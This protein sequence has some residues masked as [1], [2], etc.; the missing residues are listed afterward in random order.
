MSTNYTK[1]KQYFSYAFLLSFLVLGMTSLTLVYGFDLDYFNYSEV[2]VSAI[3]NTTVIVSIVSLVTSIVTLLGY[4]LTAF[5]SW[6]KDKR[7]QLI[8]DIDL[9]KKKLEVE[10]LRKDINK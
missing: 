2:E 9:E 7:E 5:L 3:F 4:I 6:K 8:S 10:K 1:I